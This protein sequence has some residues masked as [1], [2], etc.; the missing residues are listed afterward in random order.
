[1]HVFGPPTK[2]NDFFL[3]FMSMI[4]GITSFIIKHTEVRFLAI[5]VWVY[6][7]IYLSISLSINTINCNHRPQYFFRILCPL[8]TSWSSTYPSIYLS[9]NL[10]IHLYISIYLSI[11]LGG[12]G[13]GEVQDG[14]PRQGGQVRGLHLKT[15]GLRNAV[16]ACI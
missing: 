5:F 12:E 13:G 9:I 7:S 11:Y 14:A 4:T 15:E 3:Q 1:M 6:I 8:W 10:S 16:V 2:Y